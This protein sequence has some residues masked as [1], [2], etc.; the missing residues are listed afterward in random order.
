M[1]REALMLKIPPLNRICPRR[2]LIA[3]LAFVASGIAAGTVS[4]QESDDVRLQAN[5]KVA[6][7]EAVIDEGQN[8]LAQAREKSNVSQIDCL[9]TQLV[10][11]RGFLNVAQNANVNLKEAIERNDAEA[12][13]HHQKLLNL[14]AEK[15]DSALVHMKQCET[16][17]VSVSGETRSTT[18]RNCKIEPCLAGEDVYAP[19]AIEKQSSTGADK[20]DTSGSVDASPYM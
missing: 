14:A 7:I 5:A 10:I 19:D 17:V 11:A 12:A 4:A 2:S 8:M 20:L 6:G 18:R 1:L 15:T 13:T 16:G 9:N 3:S